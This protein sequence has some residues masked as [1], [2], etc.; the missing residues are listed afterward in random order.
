MEGDPSSKLSGHLPSKTSNHV[1]LLKLTAILPRAVRSQKHM[2]RAARI[3]NSSKT[4]NKILSPEDL[5]KA[6]WTSAVGK[7][8]AAHT[9]RLRVVRSTLVVEVEDVIWQKQLFGLSR[10]IV[11]RIQKAT[12]SMII[13]DAE[14]RICIPRREPQRA[15]TPKSTDEAEEIQDPVLKKVY[16]LSRKKAIA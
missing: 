3:V 8:I 15:A 13:T 10:Q 14:F 7:V 2:E 6:V 9:S 11:D 5:V 12:G 1:R 16:Q 4:A